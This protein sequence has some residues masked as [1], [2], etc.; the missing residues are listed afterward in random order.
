MAK[1]IQA[2]VAYGPRIEL[3]KPMTE[4]ELTE[5][6]VAATNQSKGSLMASL[7]EM[8]VQ[9]ESALKAGRIVHLPNGM[10]LEPVGKKDGTVEIH[11]RVSPDLV[12]R[13]NG[14]FRGTWLNAQ[15]IDKNEA[16]IYALW[17]ADNPT[18]L[19]EQ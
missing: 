18:D 14:N 17:D 4:E 1:K 19:I 5:N 8:D 9:I 7:A 6:V 15:N 13:V 3:T 16:E 11:V 2:W 12:K 10:H